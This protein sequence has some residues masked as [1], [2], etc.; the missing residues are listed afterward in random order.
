MIDPESSDLLARIR[1]ALHE[2]EDAMPL[3]R[4]AMDTI[5]TCAEALREDLSALYAWHER[6][7]TAYPELAAL[8]TT[9][10]DLQHASNGLDTALLAGARADLDAL[11][12]EMDADD[13]EEK[14]S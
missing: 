8:L 10:D 11:M 1:T 3:A 13:A 7:E 5:A 2:I 4:D 14:S 12:A 9:V 6:D